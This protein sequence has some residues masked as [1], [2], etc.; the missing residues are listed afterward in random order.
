MSINKQLLDPMGSICKLI[1]LNFCAV[2]T[3]ISIH[4]H[5]LS[6]DDNPSNI[7]PLLRTWFRDTKEN[8]SELFYVI[9]RV[10]KWYLVPIYKDSEENDKTRNWIQISSS[11]E[12]QR[13]IK[14]AC[15]AL[16]KLQET[17]ESGNVVLAIQFYINILEDA[18][19]GIYND[20]KLP[21]YI[22][23]REQA[24][25]NLLDYDKLKNLWDLKKIKRICELYDNC[26]AIFNDT[27]MLSLEKDALF[28]GYLKSINAILELTD[29]DFQHLMQNSNK[30]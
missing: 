25:N 15:T 7:Q 26:F 23:E 18:V 19:N 22:I 10:I 5:I 11:E 16:R 2:N 6:L 1:G 13:L 4:N 14:Y 21:R 20:N 30:G 24:C 28:S 12:L 3:R 8:I 17:Y 29:I 27:E 9:I